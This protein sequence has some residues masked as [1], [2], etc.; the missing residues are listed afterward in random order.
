[1]SGFLFDTCTVRKWYAN[2]PGVTAR[3]NALPE[4]SSL[5]ISAITRGEIEF[6]HTF[7]ASLP[8]EQARFRKWI[9]ETFE[10]PHLAVTG[11]TGDCYAALR[12]ECFNRFDK[13]NKYLESREDKLGE[14]CGIDE[15]DLWLAAQAVDRKLV[16]ITLDGME[17]IREAVD[18]VYGRN[19]ILVWPDD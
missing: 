16:L 1:M 9:R 13:K 10:I 18:A 17:R 19:H 5:F 3:V 6:S 11:S 4:E 7:P 15:N 12:R 2:R 8:A 14:K